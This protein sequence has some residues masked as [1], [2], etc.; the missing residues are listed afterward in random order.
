MKKLVKILPIL[1]TLMMVFTMVSPVLATTNNLSKDIIS[2]TPNSSNVSGKVN[3]MGR[4]I[5]GVIQ[6]VGT[7]AAVGI[8][9]VVGIKYMMGSA[10]EKAEYKKVMIPYIIGAIL[11]FAAANIANIVY[12]LAQ[13]F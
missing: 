11:L 8:L 4:T 6:V 10:E 13:N 3:E 9:M 12:S 2:T 1:M 5:L 7:I